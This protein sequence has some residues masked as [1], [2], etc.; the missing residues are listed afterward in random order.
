MPNQIIQLSGDRL[1]A[2][3]D[4]YA[5]DG[6][7]SWH[8]PAARGLAPATCYLLVE[9]EEALL[10]DTGL[11][12]HEQPLLAQLRTAVPAGAELSVLLLRQGEFDSM[13]NLPS[14]VR[15]FDVRT[16]Y[17]QYVDA[18]IWADV[19]AAEE[20]RMT[21]EWAE[22]ARLRTVLLPSD[23]TLPFGPG[24]A[25]TLDVFVPA[26]RL[27]GT[28]WVFDR[29]TGTLF[30]SDSFTYAIRSGED[31]P[32]LVTESDDTTTQ[33]QVEEHLRTTRYWWLEGAYVDELRAS[34]A[35]VFERFPVRRIA[36][37]FGCVLEGEALVRRHHAMVDAA[38]AKLGIGG[39]RPAA[40]PTTPVSTS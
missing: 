4:T 5:V 27:L 40:Q 12:V 22:G 16:I 10:I 17:G 34:L 14:I 32:W 8:P 9:G 36:P 20:R 15:A 1:S 23:G 18:P 33:A 28:Y 19:H 7:V 37:A 39:P 3:V 11:T 2:L 6:R 21:G 13:C 25:R 24:G 29:A 30:T 35:A 38:I 31:G 26:L